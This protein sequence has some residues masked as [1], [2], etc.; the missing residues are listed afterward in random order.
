MTSAA[1][2]PS[3]AQPAP[4]RLQRTRGEARIA[5][6]ARGGSTQLERL[7]QNGAAK[8]RLPRVA[9]DAPRQAVLINTAGGLT[10]GD[11]ISCDVTARGGTRAL[12]TTQ[13]CEKIYR[14]SG[15][16]A[17]VTATLAVG[18]GARL[19][20]LPQE[21]ILFDGG[22]LD[23]RLDVDLAE[24][25]TL[26]ALEA[27]VFGRTAMGETLASGAFHDRWRIRRSGRLVFADDIRFSGDIARRLAG[28]AVLN[29]G[30]ATATLLLVS[31]E[32]GRLLD[33]ARAVIGGHGGASA[34]DG[35]LVARV[36][37]GDGLALRRILVPLATL[38][39]GG[40]E[41]PKVW[42]L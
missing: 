24:G 19:D 1:F 31:D 39:L 17:E 6:R 8:L 14:S 4:P 42:H 30:C 32:A 34:W 37:A 36:A 5:F 40:T 21:T 2:S 22:R 33:A 9:A 15:G 28:P 3:E 12:V 27:V 38:L 41:L 29:G 18:A 35:K 13:A 25:A 7:Y 11:R 20:W 10:G 16:T 26:L 23:R